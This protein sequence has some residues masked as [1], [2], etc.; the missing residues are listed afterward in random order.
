MTSDAGHAHGS[1]GSHGPLA[2]EAAKLAEAFAGWVSNGFSSP[3]LAGFGESAECRA[4]PVCQLLRIAQ[5]SQPEVFAHLADASASLLAALRAAV[6]S[7][8]ASWTAGSRPVS[9]R[10]DIS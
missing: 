2:E 10:I 3:L 1:P 9:E 5:G 8:Q 4:C 6:E 7:S